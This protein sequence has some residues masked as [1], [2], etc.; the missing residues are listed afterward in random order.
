MSQLKDLTGMRFG[1][2]TVLYRNNSLTKKY[3]NGYGYYWHCLCDCGTEKDVSDNK[4]K[5]GKTKSCGCLKREKTIERNKRHGLRRTRLYNVYYTMRAR[6][7]NPNNHEYENYGGRGIK[8]CDE[9]LVENG[10]KNFYEWANQNGYV[11][12]AKTGSCTID[13]IDV[14]GDYCPENCRWVT[15]KVQANNTRTNV[16]IEHKGETHSI[17]EWAD[18]LRIDYIR[19]HRALKIHNMSFDESVEYALDRNIRKARS[20]KGTKKK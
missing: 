11:E 1:R 4:L 15:Q 19:F 8:I 14:D 5:N 16:M 7:L 3:K 13:R 2:L 9:W 12:D 17:S 18:I 6:C 10:I 20:D